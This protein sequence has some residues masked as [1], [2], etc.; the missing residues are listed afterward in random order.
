MIKKIE[1]Q[2]EKKREEVTTLPP[3]Q[4]SS[5]VKN[6]IDAEIKKIRRENET[7]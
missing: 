4:L 6:A 7:S 5:Q 1:D 3:V 2:P